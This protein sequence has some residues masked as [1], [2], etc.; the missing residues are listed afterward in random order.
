MFG[1]DARETKLLRSLKTPA[2]VQ[3]FLDA[4]SINFEADGETC[5][6]PR[7]A[8]RERTA[9]CMEGAML[10][11]A[12]L[13]VQGRPPVVLDLK[14]SD[15]DDDHVVALFW[16]R[17]CVGA[18]SK[19]NHGTLRYRDAVYASV[20]ELAM[21]YF[22]EYTEKRGRKVLRSYSRPVDLSRFDAHGWMTS[23]DDLTYIA[24]YVDGVRHYALLTTAQIAKLRKADAMERRIGAI[25]EW[26]EPRRRIRRRRYH[27]AADVPKPRSV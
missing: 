21:S 18:V 5:M 12:A 15:E 6:S 26:P 17:G 20:R 14:A 24:D 4:L 10:A 11:A 16:E 3:D 13:R 1:F 7:R 22:H 27:D 8:M 19:T 2:D 23:E 9:H 25:L